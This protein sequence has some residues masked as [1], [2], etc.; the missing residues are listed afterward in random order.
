MTLAETLRR[1]PPLLVAAIVMT[2]MALGVQAQPYPNKPIRLIM[3]WPP[4]GPAEGIARPVMER[5]SQALGRPIIIEPK[6]GAAAM[7]GTQYVARQPA[8]G[9]TLLLS[10]VGSTTIAPAL[11]KQLAYD[12]IKDFEHITLIASATLVL[13]VRPELPFGS[14]PELIAYAKANPGKLAYGSMGTGST[15]H[16][17]G[18]LLSM[19]AG[20]DLL[21]VPYNGVPPVLQ[22][23][24][25]GRIQGT[26]IGYL[27]VQAH[28]KAG[29]LRLIAIASSTNRSSIA[30][31]IPT[32][33][34]TLSEYEADVWYGLAAPAGTPKEIVHRLYTEVSK[35]LR[36][37]QVMAKLRETGSEPGGMAPDAFLA[38]IRQD[39]ARWAKVVEGAHIER[40]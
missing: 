22:D 5:L 25:G 34:E 3:P 1:T 9:Y 23:L 4:G 24:L 26:F 33:S 14:I 36:E 10:H 6:A 31:D 13:V 19:M 16:L 37:P 18:E 32:V 8:D 7:I 15:S 29:T 11:Q 27:P 2:M 28:V 20:I 21:H 38:K 12:P 17:A 39:T 35:I 30:P 40:Q